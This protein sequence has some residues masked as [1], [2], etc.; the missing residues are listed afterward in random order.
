[1]YLRQNCSV[2]ASEA[3]LPLDRLTRRILPLYPPGNTGAAGATAAA[4]AATVA[5][6]T[7]V[8]EF[9][10]ILFSSGGYSDN[11]LLGIENN[12]IGD[13]SLSK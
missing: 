5:A 7:G 4:G 1:M 6:V 3:I 9:S 2:I 11:D 10:V 12:G 8:E 13:Q